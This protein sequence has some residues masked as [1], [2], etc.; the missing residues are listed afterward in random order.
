MEWAK[1]K[2]PATYLSYFLLIVL[3]FF[4]VFP[5]FWV[6][7]TSLKYEAQ[8]FRTPLEFWPN[9]IVLSNYTDLFAEGQLMLFMKNSLIIAIPNVFVSTV[10]A[11]CAGYG[12][13]KFK[14][15]GRGVL[16]SLI[17]LLRMVPGILFFIPYFLMITNM[18]LLNTHLGLI[19]CSIPGSVLFSTWILQGFFKSIPNEIEEAAEIDGLGVF[20]RLFFIVVPISIP[21]IVTA[22][23]FTFLGSWNE[24][25]LASTLLRDMSLFTMPLGIKQFSNAVNERIYWG[26]IMANATIYLLPVLLFT[27]ISQ[28][29]LVKGLSA[30]AVKQ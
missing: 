23:L 11:I 28:R 18:G 21:A 14:F 22:M 15:A 19:I 17:L 1:W 30:G 13:A 24:Y 6:F 10:I 5:V 25:L 27:F 2:R 9:P 20:R 26:K 8:T 4:L 3:V 29:G 16:M 12:F 7:I